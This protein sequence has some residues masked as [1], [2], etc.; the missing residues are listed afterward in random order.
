MPSGGQR[1]AVTMAVANSQGGVAK[2]G[3]G[4]ENF[5]GEKSLFPEA[6]PA[7]F[8]VDLACVIATCELRSTN[9]SLAKQ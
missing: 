7:A 2:P 9:P 1:I 3:R 6:V 8:E 4:T 5:G